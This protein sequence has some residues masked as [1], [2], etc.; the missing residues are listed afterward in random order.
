VTRTRTKLGLIHKQ[1]L[2]LLEAHPEGISEG[3][4]R[5]ALKIPAEKMTQFGRRRRDL[6]QHYRIEKKRQGIDVKYVL[7]GPLAEPLDDAPIG[8]RLR[9]EALR[10]ARGRCQMCGRTIVEDG[11]R[12]VVDHKLPR[13]W[14]GKT[15][16]DNLWAICEDCNAG[17]KDLFASMDSPH[18]RQAMA[19]KSPHIRIGELLKAG[20]VGKE[21]P[22]HLIQFVANQDQWDKRLRELRYLG[23]K[24]TAG[25][26]NVKGGRRQSFYILRHFTEYPP[27]VSKW[28]QD[29]ERK[30]AKRNKKR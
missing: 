14:G 11:I 13:T 4:M 18:V 8:I 24:I 27:N 2:A 25:T 12:L 1:M 30:R 21:V 22:S 6:H 26:R 29:F 16:R 28:I 17:K 9:A 23:W 10:E 5:A 7:V 3:E 19:N 20:G 15:E